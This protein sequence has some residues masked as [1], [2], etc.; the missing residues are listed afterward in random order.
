MRIEKLIW[1]TLIALEN[2]PSEL[3][4]H[5]LE[6]LLLEDMDMYPYAYAYVNEGKSSQ[7]RK[8]PP[9]LTILLVNKQFN[10]EATRL[11]YTKATFNVTT[12]CR[13]NRFFSLVT[14]DC[15]K[16]SPLYRRIYADS[17]TISCYDLLKLVDDLLH[18]YGYISAQ[19]KWH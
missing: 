9:D 13:F 8:E 6:Q 12:S 17:E 7:Q 4:S 1:R 15:S 11:L 2:L 16:Q 18:E 14:L 19:L 3:F 10:A 5:V